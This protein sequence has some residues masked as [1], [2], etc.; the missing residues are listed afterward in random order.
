MSSE[1]VVSRPSGQAGGGEAPPMVSVVIKALNEESKI[2]QCLESVLAEVERLGVSW[3]IVL[4]DSISTDRTVEI[5]LKYP[6]R[7]VQFCHLE[8]RGCGSG[9]QL[10]YQHSR[11]SVL[12][13][14]DGDM[15]VQPGFLSAALQALEQDPTLGG[16]AGLMSDAVVR[17]AFD[18]HRVE[19]AVSSVAKDELWLNGG[20][21]YRRDAIEMA[22]GYAANRNLKGWEE[23]DLGMRVRAAGWHLRRIHVPAVT[24]VGHS[25]G[26]VAVLRSLWRSGRSYSSGVLLRQALGHPWFLDTV[27]LLVHPLGMMSWWLLG[28]ACVVWSFAQASGTAL[29]LWGGASLLVLL[30]MMLIKRSIRRGALS[31][32]M[33]NY[34]AAGLLCGL[35]LPWRSPTERIDSVE[36]SNSGSGA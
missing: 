28:L 34:L 4:G 14:L 23:A 9:V 30:G 31:V 33:W 22:G 21:V 15:M 7:V 18:A 35:F 11:G 6:V 29:M 13:F 8:D 5:A 19:A 3:E 26:T 32:F 24:H 36:L 16:V 10:G 2:Q 20:G 12:F 25:L 1:R 17:N 27:R